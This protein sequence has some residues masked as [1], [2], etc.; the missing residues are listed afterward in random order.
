MTVRS[1]TDYHFSVMA[2]PG[3]SNQDVAFVSPIENLFTGNQSRTVGRE[4]LGRVLATGGRAE[5]PEQGETT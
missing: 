5:S 1:F 4:N 3:A 2:G